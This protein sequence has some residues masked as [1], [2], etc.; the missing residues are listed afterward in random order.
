MLRPEVRDYRPLAEGLYIGYLAS[1]EERVGVN[2]PFY[3][4]RFNVPQEGGQE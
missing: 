1:A 3:S 2:G 4:L